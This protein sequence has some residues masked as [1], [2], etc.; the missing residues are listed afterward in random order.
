VFG[1]QFRFCCP[2]LTIFLVLI[3][4]FECSAFAQALADSKVVNWLECDASYVTGARC[5]TFRVPLD[6][7]HPGS[8][9]LEL[10]FVVLRA[11]TGPAAPD[12]VFHI[13]GGPGQS[14]SELAKSVP[15]F[16]QSVNSDREVVLLD[17]R[18]TGKSHPLECAPTVAG[19]AQLQ[20]LLGDLFPVDWV[21]ACYL[22]LQVRPE[23][24]TTE[25]AMQDLHNL[26]IALGYKQFD[27]YGT[28]YGTRAVFSY[29]RQFP[30]DGVRTA[31]LKSPVPMNLV[32]AQD[33]AADAQRSLD[34]LFTHCAADPACNH[35]YPFVKSEFRKILDNLD[36]EPAKTK[37]LN[38]STS[39][40]EQVALDR[41]LIATLVRSTLYRPQ[42]AAKL[43]L[44]IHRAYL[45]DWGPF[46][47]QAVAV[48]SDIEGDAAGLYL[49]IVC[50]EDFPFIDDKQAKA[51][52]QGT[53]LR[54]YW[55]L[56]LRQGCR[57]WHAKPV[58]K[59]FR[60]PVNSSVPVLLITGSMDPTTPPPYTNAAMKYLTHAL[61]LNFENGSH[62]FN[63]GDC[64]LAI[65]KEFVEKG[66]GKEIDTSCASKV[67]F[68][69]FARN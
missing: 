46:A 3:V 14:A 57:L 22:R 47:E 4:A 41:S 7:T 12:P 67:E 51:R 35:E 36:H 55:Y 15:R 63:S 1:L 49:S 24:F 37:V 48:R 20:Y 27:L 38:P 43:P 64:E 60:D 16:L 42:A 26:S 44:M 13:S 2:K 29:L 50:S 31:V 28:S 30:G 19:P 61:H 33:F 56:Q 5:G 65:I 39:T 17:Q 34:L 32:I 62:A 18:G 52:S 9:T 21:K 6:Y 40:P 53:F 11:R 58:K 10:F 69:E 66:S 59:S 8:G 23:F 25:I 54:M 45:G 68:P